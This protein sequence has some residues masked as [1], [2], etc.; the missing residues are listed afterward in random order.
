MLLLLLSYIKVLVADSGSG[1]DGHHRVTA[2]DAILVLY[3]T[4]IQY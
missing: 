1:F 2:R 4:G 3:A